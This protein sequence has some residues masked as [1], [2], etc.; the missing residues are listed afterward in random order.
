MV[1]D[2]FP[3]PDVNVVYQQDSA[4]LTFVN[5]LL[6]LW[7]Q[8]WIITKHSDTHAYLHISLREPRFNLFQYQELFP[9]LESSHRKYN[10]MFEAAFELGVFLGEK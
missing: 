3:S 1:W 5:K 2:N 4:F 10:Y 7:I 6:L 9:K 8:I